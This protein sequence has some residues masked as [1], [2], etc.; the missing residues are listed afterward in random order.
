MLRNPSLES[1]EKPKSM[2]LSFT[3]VHTFGFAESKVKVGGEFR[4]VE[5]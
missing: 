2:I 5:R 4:K 3:L 1:K